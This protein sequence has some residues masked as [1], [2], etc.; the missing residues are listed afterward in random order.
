MRLAVSELPTSS[1]GMRLAVSQLPM[2]SQG[3][4][5]AVSEP[6]TVWLEIFED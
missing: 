2:S 4:R 6:P 1:L 5:L 3:M